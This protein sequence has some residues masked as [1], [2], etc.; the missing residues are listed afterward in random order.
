LHRSSFYHLLRI[1]HS[2]LGGWCQLR[3]TS[4]RKIRLPDPKITVKCK[5]VLAAASLRSFVA[6]LCPRYSSLGLVMDG[7]ANIQLECIGDFNQMR[8]E[9]G[10]LSPITWREDG[11]YDAPN[12]TI[13]LLGW[14]FDILQKFYFENTRCSYGF[15]ACRILLPSELTIA[16]KRFAFVLVWQI[17]LETLS[18]TKRTISNRVSDLWYSRDCLLIFLHKSIRLNC[19]T[20]YILLLWGHFWYYRRILI[21]WLGWD[22]MVCSKTCQHMVFWYALGE[23]PLFAAC[24]INLRS[25]G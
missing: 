9:H 12:G 18:W 14:E 10:E 5:C 17:S 15:A 4:I 24:F 19:S 16:M 3:M 25:N 11:C 8:P 23:W 22:H 1:I 20:V 2:T 21:F 7:D 13:R 6:I